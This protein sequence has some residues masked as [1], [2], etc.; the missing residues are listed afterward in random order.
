[1][2]EPDAELLRRLAS[3]EV[4]QYL[5]DIITLYNRAFGTGSARRDPSNVLQQLDFLIDLLSGVARR[6]AAVRKNLDAL[7][8]LRATFSNADQGGREPRAACP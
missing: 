7:D 1:M 6:N 2:T 4:D 5:E 3:G 8:K